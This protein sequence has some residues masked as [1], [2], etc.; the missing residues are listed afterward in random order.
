M[1]LAYRRQQQNG[2]SVI[3]SFISSCT[4]LPQEVKDVG[5][6]GMYQYEIKEA[7]RGIWCPKIY[8]GISLQKLIAL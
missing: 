3:W 6:L 4:S 2:V 7:D 5:N 1:R 8:E